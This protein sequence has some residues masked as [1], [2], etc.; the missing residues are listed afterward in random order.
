[1]ARIGIDIV[2]V[3]Q[4][5]ASIEAFGDRYVSRV[6]SAR[7]RADSAGS[8][9]RLAARFAA[10][11]ATLKVLSQGDRGVDWR[12]IEVVRGENGEPRIELAGVAHDLA[13]SLG[14]VNI[15]VSMSHDAEYATAVVLAEL[16]R[17][18]ARRGSFALRR[19]LGRRRE[20]RCR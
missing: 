10:K 15:T 19:K 9:D 12:S 20:T 18:R 14:L 16:K 4:V 17:D 5:R 6:Y 8:P 1:M 2:E 11:E 7:E 13:Q 3:A